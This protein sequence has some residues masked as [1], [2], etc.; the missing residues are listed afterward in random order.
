MKARNEGADATQAL[1]FVVLTKKHSGRFLVFG[2]YPDEIE[3]RKVC[4]L[5]A[6]AGAVARIVGPNDELPIDEGTTP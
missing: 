3:A 6:W 4:R 1:P 5:L 2:R